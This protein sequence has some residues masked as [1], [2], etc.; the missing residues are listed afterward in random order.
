MT[1]LDIV[2]R[3]FDMNA[4][5]ILAN[6]W[7]HLKPQDLAK[8]MQVSTM[9]SLAIQT[10]AEALERYLHAKNHALDQNVQD[11]SDH[12]CSRMIFCLN[13]KAFG[14]VSNLISPVKYKER[15]SP[16]FNKKSSNE[17]VVS[18][19]KFRHKLFTEEA[20]NLGP[21]EKL[22]PC[23]RCTGPCRIIPNEN[24]GICS[25]ISCQFNFCTLC[26]C[27]F[28]ME[29]P[30]RLVRGCKIRSSPTSSSKACVSTKSSKRRLRRL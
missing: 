23:P 18:P 15:R 22:Q 9:W 25:R 17:I 27:T 11:K 6:I 20:K 26:N 30:C 2:K 21:D 16:R 8:C 5:H 7:W 13:R 29:A 1:S 28:H 4:R 3:L 19:S 14:S 12:T 24:K 10:D